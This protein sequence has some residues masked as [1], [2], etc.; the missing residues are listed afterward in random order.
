MLGW[1][2]VVLWGHLLVDMYHQ[3]LGAHKTKVKVAIENLLTPKAIRVSNNSR[4][5]LILQHRVVAVVPILKKIETLSTIGTITIVI[6]HRVTTPFAKKIVI[7]IL[8]CL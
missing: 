8:V 4:R 5:D 1:D 6:L 2:M 3:G 7:N